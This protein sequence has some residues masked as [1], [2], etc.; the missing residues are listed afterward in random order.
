MDKLTEIWRIISGV[1]FLQNVTNI[2]MV[3]RWYQGIMVDCMYHCTKRSFEEVQSLF[4]LPMLH[5]V[6]FS[7][8]TLKS[9]SV[10]TFTPSYLHA[11]NSCFICVH[12]W[13]INVPYKMKWSYVCTTTKFIW[14]LILF[15]WIFLSCR[16]KFSL[17]SLQQNHH[18]LFESLMS[19]AQDFRS[20]T[21]E[22]ARCLVGWMPCLYFP[23]TSGLIMMRLGLQVIF[24]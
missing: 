16:D 3:P 8:C 9:Q 12:F 11:L 20:H 13:E 24:D 7:I 21:K 19:S 17:Q 23:S 22:L 2:C 15:E 1:L 10:H 14:C 18:T 5:C 4:V 6:R